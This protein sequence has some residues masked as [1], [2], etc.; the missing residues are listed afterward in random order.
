M[1]ALDAVTAVS[2][3]TTLQDVVTAIIGMFATILARVSI[4]PL[5]LLGI[6]IFLV[7]AVIYLTY[8]ALHGRG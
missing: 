7:S 8:K 5:L 4:E 6:G 3:L 1:I 2:S